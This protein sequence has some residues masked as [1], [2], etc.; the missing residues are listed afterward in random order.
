M[1]LFHRDGKIPRSLLRG[2]SILSGILIELRRQ[3][4]CGFFCAATPILYKISGASI[5]CPRKRLAEIP[6][7]VSGVDHGLRPW[8]NAKRRRLTR[9]FFIPPL[10]GVK[11]C[12]GLWPRLFTAPFKP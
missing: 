7:G 4:S 10:S 12:H 11:Q 5:H 8:G 6:L 1:F 3:N 9:L 2:L